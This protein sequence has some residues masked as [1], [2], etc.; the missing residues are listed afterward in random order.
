M[1][2]T[3]LLLLF[4]KLKF[5]YAIKGMGYMGVPISFSLCE[6]NSEALPTPPGGGWA[7]HYV[8]AGSTAPPPKRR[9]HTDQHFRHCW[10]GFGGIRV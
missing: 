10:G 2:D 1:F 8:R 7:M 5:S 4:Q 3:L 6:W 9:T